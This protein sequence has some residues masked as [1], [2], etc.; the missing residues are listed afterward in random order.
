MPDR[1]PARL[2]RRPPPRGPDHVVLQGPGGGRVQALPHRLPGGGDRGG[3]PGG[4]PRDHLQ[5]ARLVHMRVKLI[6]YLVRNTYYVLSTEFKPLTPVVGVEGRLGA[7]L[8]RLVAPF[9]PVGGALL[10]DVDAV[11]RGPR[12]GLRRI[13]DEL[14]RAAYRF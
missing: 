2:L 14:L 8:G 1:H 7:R 12:L 10:R 9:R 4:G 13:D 11:R 6:S 3:R 5:P